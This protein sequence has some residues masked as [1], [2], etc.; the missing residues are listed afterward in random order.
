L[1]RELGGALLREDAGFHTYQALEAGFR[2]AATRPP[3][4]ARTLLVGVARYLAAHSPTRRER[5][6]TFGIAA[7]LQRGESVYGEDADI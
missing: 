4:E 6:Q 3:E 1:R 7:R 5:E 2:Q